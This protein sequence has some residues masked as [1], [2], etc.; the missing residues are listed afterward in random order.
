MRSWRRHLEAT[1][2]TACSTSMKCR[3]DCSWAE[4]DK[5]GET[6][7]NVWAEMEDCLEGTLTQLYRQ[8]W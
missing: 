7:Q 5:E 3:Y 8:R 1:T 6:E 4:I 2:D